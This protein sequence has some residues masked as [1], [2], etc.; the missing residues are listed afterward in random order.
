MRF[1]VEKVL[2]WFLIGFNVA[3]VTGL[4]IQVSKRRNEGIIMTPA[5]V[6]PPSKPT[7]AILINR[8]A[9]QQDLQ[10][11][12]QCRKQLLELLKA[13][14]RYVKDHNGRYP[15][16]LTTDET[17]S[18]ES[19]LFDPDVGLYPRYISDKKLLVCPSALEGDLLPGRALPQSYLYLLEYTDLRE[20]RLEKHFILNQ[21]PPQ[22]IPVIMC[23]A[24]PSE[25]RPLGTHGLAIF[26]DGS[27]KWV[28]SED[29]ADYD[30]QRTKYENIR[31]QIFSTCMA[32]F[33]AYQPEWTKP[34]P[35]NK[36]LGERCR[37][38]AEDILRQY[39]V[40]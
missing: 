35:F 15:A 12:E 21:L 40:D 38:V 10:E 25:P 14:R 33:G 18:I 1:K 2:F 5:G 39:G 16:F 19:P 36:Q 8:R 6:P 20:W 11:V 9:S 7:R 23:R 28:T 24:H 34:N 37:R 22:K 4:V 31:D 3:L 30:R 13:I 27:I 17:V 26:L 32:K 29:L